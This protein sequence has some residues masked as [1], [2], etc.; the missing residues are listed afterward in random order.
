MS[1]SRV[2]HTLW[3]RLPVTERVALGWLLLVF[4]LTVV[5]FIWTP[6]DPTHIDIGQRLRGPN[7]AHPFGT[8]HFGRDVLSMIMV[9]GR[10]SLA[11][12]VG[13]VGLG[14]AL[15]VPL[16]LLA[17]ARRGILDAL[18]MRMNDVLF[19]LPSVLLA[20]LLTAVRGPGALTAIIAIGIFNIPV[21][22][23]VAR[24]AALSLWSRDFVASARTV[25]RSAMGISRD[26][27]LPHLWV[28][29]LTQMM[30][31]MSVGITAEA[32]LS[33]IGLGV[34]PPLASWGRML[35]EAQTFVGVAPW[36]A[37]FPGLAIILTVMSFGIVADHLT[38]P[39]RGPDHTAPVPVS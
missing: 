28:L 39:R 3:S 35:N 27:I 26:H 7:F 12:A 36:L 13:S 9:G 21:F 11:I 29:L 6:H 23:R 18:V 20:I 19:A 33:Y 37:L 10:A 25:G 1:A 32:G 14:M 31:Q 16:G 38:G 34:Q 17:A 24:G 2:F 5:A 22:A 30:I 4:V 8:D 15:G